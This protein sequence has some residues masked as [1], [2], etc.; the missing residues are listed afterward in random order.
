MSGKGKTYYCPLDLEPID[1][2]NLAYE[3]AFGVGFTE[4]K[5][6]EDKNFKELTSVGDESLIEKSEERRK[7]IFGFEDEESSLIVLENGTPGGN[8]GLSFLIENVKYNGQAGSEAATDEQKGNGLDM[9]TAN[10]AAQDEKSSTRKIRPSGNR[11]FQRPSDLGD[12]N[13]VDVRDDNEGNY[14]FYNKAGQ[15]VMTALPCC[16]HC[17]MRLPIDWEKA[18][19]FLIVSLFAPTGSGK[20]TML[21]SLMANKWEALEKYGSING[22]ELQVTPANYSAG[23]GFYMKM[24]KLADNLRNNGNCPDMTEKN[25]MIQPLF[26]NVNYN[27][28]RML[29]GI[30]DNAGENLEDPNVIHKYYL[31]T[32]IDNSDVDMFL[33]DPED[34]NINLDRKVFDMKS[35]KKSLPNC[36]IDDIKEQGEK[37][38]SAGNKR[39]PAREILDEACKGTEKGI[40]EVRIKK[41]PLDVYRAVSRVRGLRQS[42][43]VKQNSR[44]FLGVIIKS[45]LLRPVIKNEEYSELFRDVRVDPSNRNQVS[46]TSNT[47]TDMIK[48]YKLFGDL[49]DKEI[50]VIGSK[51]NEVR[52]SWHCIS[53]LGCDAEM[54]GQLKG[55]YAPIRLAEPIIRCIVDRIADNG[56]IDENSGRGGNK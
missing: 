24:S 45:D 52:R 41:G 46:T 42:A 25:K 14:A 48:E 39:I 17:H 51:Y 18:E 12:F 6:E 9:S 38:A 3:L 47:I 55:K 20:T 50:D 36:T 43:Q 23:G 5:A 16:P 33:F 54:H 40:K 11:G 37:Q 29:V 10:K 2:N 26:L 31:K 44:R 53:A 15:N 4:Q 30:Y 35:L 19:D 21:L 13:L 28:H 1:M 56:W 32:V 8:S 34:M 27:G 7:T 49:D 22:S